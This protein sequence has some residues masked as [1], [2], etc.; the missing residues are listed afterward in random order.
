[1]F[2]FFFPRLLDAYTHQGEWYKVLE[3]A[4]MAMKKDTA[5]VY[6]PQVQG[7]ALLN[8]N[9]YDEC[10]KASDQLIARNDS[11]P[12]PWYSAGMSYFNQAVALDKNVRLSNKE[13]L[14]MQELYKKAMTYMKRFRQLAP[15][16]QERWVFPLYT[17]YLNLNMGTE[18]DEIDRLIKKGK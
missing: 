11:L 9:R 1:M 17:I 13:R 18:F 5:S 14:R 4:E 16:Q 8:L 6:Y 12:E 7:T 3:I 10:I 2:P 15:D